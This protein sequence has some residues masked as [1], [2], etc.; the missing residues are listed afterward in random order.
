[1]TGKGSFVPWCA[2]EGDGAEISDR[3]NARR[4]MSTQ[5]NATPSVCVSSDGDCIVLSEMKAMT[6]Q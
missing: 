2:G 6:L 1:M 5:R 3:E 4:K